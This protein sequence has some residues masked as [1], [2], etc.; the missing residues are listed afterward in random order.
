VT[1]PADL[2]AATRAYVI[3]PAGCGKTELIAAAVAAM[4]SRQLVLTHTHAGVGALRNRLRNYGVPKARAR[5]ETIAGF[6]LRIACAYPSTSGFDVQRPRDAQWGEVYAA[7]IRVLSMRVGKDIL[8]ASYSGAFVDEYQDCVTTQHALVLELAD[9]L[10]VRILGDPLQ[11]IFDF[12]GQQLVDWN[13]IDAAFERLPDL[14]TPWRWKDT[15]PDLGAWLLSIR[16]DLL[17]GTRPDFRSGPV[18]VRAYSEAAQVLACG[19]RIDDTSVVAIRKWPKDAHN[20]ASK[21]GGNFTSMEE[22]ESKDL[23]AHARAIGSCDG[24][25]RALQLIRIG[26]S[27]DSCRRP[28]TALATSTPSRRYGR[29]PPTQHPPP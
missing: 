11:G 16:S 12:K 20:V 9:T 3:A 23:L 7:A 27:R 15:N 19:Q 13:G 25:E 26:S 21:L 10:P 4:D 29:S 1:T 2:A 22:M 5:V 24:P 28:R 6:A 17:A 18:D 14:A 8:A